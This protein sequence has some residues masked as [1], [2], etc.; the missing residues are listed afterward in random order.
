VSEPETRIVLKE[1]ES[2]EPSPG[3]PLH[4]VFLRDAAAHETATRL[5][6]EGI[7]QI[8]ELR[9][10][11]RIA[12]AS[13]VGRI[14]LG[15]IEL[16]VR[17]KIP[18]LPL[19]SL[20][21]YTYGLRDLRLFQAADFATA[22]QALQELLVSQLE[23]EAEELLARGL[24]RRY[25][26]RR[27]AM[28]SP[29]GRVDI[30]QIA[31]NGGI[32]RAAIPS[33]YY[34][35][36][37]DTLLNRVLLAGLRLGARLTDDL[38]LRTRLRRTAGILAATI[39][40][41]HLDRHLYHEALRQA[42]RLTAVYRPALTLIGLLLEGH[43]S[44]LDADSTSVPLQ[45]F[46][47]DMQR[48]FERLLSRFLRENLPDY[49]FR[50]QFRLTHMLAY[51]P[52]HNPRGRKAPT[53]R[54]DYVVEQ[55]SRIVA[56]LDAKYRDLWERELPRDM[57]YQ[58]AIY[59]LSQRTG[60][61]ASILYPTTHTDAREARIEIRDPV[62]G[63]GHAWIILRPVHL[64]ELAELVSAPAGVMADRA[65]QAFAHQLAFGL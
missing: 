43:G 16:T 31:R 2:C 29:R 49:G 4:G 3:S 5:T 17:P 19:L 14:R 27:E 28:T 40:A 24:S 30:Q 51:L 13:Y 54:P 33:I 57:L 20:L 53:P 15:S 48:F 7:L 44:T 21:R 55:D 39:T 64:Q 25:E 35:R 61:T 62:Y 10:G 9:H 12:T 56:M 60:R 52:D 6:R 41:V 37:E 34:P 65:R 22:P 38:G 36:L 11:L 59:A 50:D 42:N 1:W 47:F 58:L 32:M 63:H 18:D 46:L 45:G 23:S 8:D 26:Q